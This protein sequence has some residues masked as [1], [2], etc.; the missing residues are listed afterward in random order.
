VLSPESHP[1][2]SGLSTQDSA[3]LLQFSPSMLKTRNITAY[4]DLLILFTRYGRKDF[5]L[6]F[7]PQNLLARTMSSR[8]RS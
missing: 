3:L 5:R 4:R 8:S 1:T 2:F 6:S 7:D